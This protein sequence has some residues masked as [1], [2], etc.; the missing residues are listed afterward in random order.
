MFVTLFDDEG[1]ENAVVWRPSDTVRT[2]SGQEFSPGLGGCQVGVID[3]KQRQNVTSAG[4][5]SVEGAMFSIP[6]KEVL[7]LND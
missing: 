6:E 3:I 4:P 7:H 1:D 2:F 5:E